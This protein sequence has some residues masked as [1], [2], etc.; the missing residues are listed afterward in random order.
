M[1]K[2]EVVDLVDGRDR[3]VGEATLEKCLSEG[4]LHRAVA[5]LVARS[6]GR[7]LIQ[8]R[9]R[10]DHWQPGRWTLSCTGHVRAGEGYAHAA[11]RELAE[12]L[13]LSPAVTQ[14]AKVFLPK[15]RSRGSVEWEVVSLYSAMSDE[16]PRVDPVE[17]EGVRVVT[18]AELDALMG[19]R[20]L[21]PDAKMMIAEYW[22]ANRGRPSSRP[23]RRAPR[24]PA[25]ASR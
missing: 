16:S 5:V 8:V 17:L 2:D 23:S 4:L 10:K 24:R 22:R 20:R 21:T 9:S 18:R 11:R 7:F 12:E 13:G 25:P 14:L 6:D 15:I 19:G 3:K 1:G